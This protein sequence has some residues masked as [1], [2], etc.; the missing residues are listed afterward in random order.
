MHGERCVRVPIVVGH[1]SPEP[2]RRLER[3]S[4]GFAGE[5]DLG[6][7]ETSS[8]PE[9]SSTSTFWPSTST[10]E[11]RLT[12][13]RTSVSL[14]SRSN[15]SE[16]SRFSSRR[17]SPDPDLIVRRCRSSIW[18]TRTSVGGRWRGVP[19]G[20]STLGSVTQTAGYDEDPLYL[21]SLS[22][23]LRSRSTL[24]PFSRDRGPAKRRGS[25]PSWPHGHRAARSGGASRETTH[26]AADPTPTREPA[27][28]RG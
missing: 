24:Q 17:S 1:L 26:D 20:S 13:R 7:H 19:G 27:P 22:H 23:H 5:L 16:V 14:H 18:R 8:S 10:I 6:K 12:I 11:R 21:D 9:Y 3:S 2:R 25:R 4:L 28:D 15:T